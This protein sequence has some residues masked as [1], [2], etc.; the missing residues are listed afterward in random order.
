MKVVLTIWY[1]FVSLVLEIIIL[2]KVIT[3]VGDYGY[4]QLWKIEA[5]K[6]KYIE[7][8]E[9]GEK[10]LVIDS[11]GEKSW[12]RNLRKWIMEIWK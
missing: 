3:L 11:Y 1:I 9:T 8:I 2:T 5:A 7:D 10:I 4:S 6:W 12:W